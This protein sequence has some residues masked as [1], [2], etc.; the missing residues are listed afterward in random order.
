MAVN[1]PTRRTT[2][3]A[4]T[5]EQYGSTEVL[6]PLGMRSGSGKRPRRS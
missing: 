4:F 3:R 1:A 2:M 6:E 5:Y